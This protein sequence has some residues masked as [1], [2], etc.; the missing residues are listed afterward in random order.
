MIIREEFNFH[1]TDS[2]Y[3]YRICGKRSSRYKSLFVGTDSV[4]KNTEQTTEDS[5]GTLVLIVVFNIYESYIT[6]LSSYCDH[7]RRVQLPFY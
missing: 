1:F 6:E 2:F 3:N 7:K 5:K 4:S